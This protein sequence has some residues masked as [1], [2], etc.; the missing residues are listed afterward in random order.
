MKYWN[1]HAETMSRDELEKL[2]LSRLNSTLHRVYDHVPFY[3]EQLDA[4]GIKPDDI[5]TLDD[6]HKIPFTTKAEMQASYPYK[7]FAVPLDDI[8]RIHASS[9]TTGQPTVVGY[10]KNDLETWSE[11]IARLLVAGGVT[12]KDIVQVSFGY[13]LFTGGFGLH[14]GIEKIGATVIPLSSGNT[15]RQLQIM[16][17][18]GST[19]IICTPSYAIYLGEILADRGIGFDKIK[20][21]VGCFGAEPWT[22]AM[23]KEIETR[24]NISATDNYGLSEV[25]GPGVSYECQAKDGMHI[26]ED[27]F[28]V[29]IINPEN[30][31]VLPYG[32]TGELVITT[33]TK[34]GIPVLRYRTRDITSLLPKKCACGRTFIRMTKP[35]GRSDDML[36]IRGVNVFPSQVETVLVEMAET[37]PHYELIVTREGALDKLEVK[38]ELNENYFSDEMRVMHVLEEKIKNRLRN[39]LGLTAKISLVAPKTIERSVGKA[40]R[41]IDLRDYLA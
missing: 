1:E 39:A 12:K 40:K 11:L 16:Q 13:G 25:M 14:Y 18:F 3:K 37:E 36:I 31:E 32:Q 10:T 15:D 19:V 5:K 22:E 28:I 20:L 35:R 7:M 24:L 29:E 30:G 27:N 9:G 2:Q 41:V 38:V 21:R 33:L 4:L 34:E 6:F 26:N 17:E 23:R 8:I